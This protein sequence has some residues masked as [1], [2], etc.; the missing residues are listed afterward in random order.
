MR[1]IRFLLAAPVVLGGSFIL[2]SPAFAGD[3]AAKSKIDA[4]TVFPSGAEV[5]R[6][7]KVKLEAGEHTLLV[8]DVTAQALPTS[9]RVEA[10]TTGKLEIGSVDARKISLSSADPTVAQSARKKLSDQIEKLQDEK[11]EQ[12]NII[13]VAEAERAY[14]QNLSKLPQTSGAASSSG[15]HEDWNALFGVIG[16]HSAEVAKTVTEAKLKQRKIERDIKELRKEYETAEGRPEDRTQVRV[17]VRADAPLEATLSVRYQVGA[18]SWT[19]FYDARLATGDKE[20]GAASTLGITRRASIAQTTGEDWEDV[21]L[22]LSTTRPGTATAA[23]DL[24]MLSVDFGS[25]AAPAG[26]MSG[27]LD[28]MAQQSA[29][30]S[31]S[32]DGDLEENKR[33]LFKAKK[34]FA[35]TEKATLQQPVAASTFQTVYAIPGRTTIKTTGEAKRLQISAEGVEPTLL[36]RAVPR[37]DHTAYLYAKFNLAKSSSPMLPGQVSLFRDGVFVGS[38]AF[39]QLAPGEDYELGF[40]ADERVKVRRIVTEDKKGE[41][42]TFTTSRVEERRYANMIKNLHSRVIQLQVVDRA[43]VAMHQDIKVE[44][45]MDK[46]PQPTEKDVNDR[47]GTMV[48]EMK[49]EP[50]EEKMLGFGYRV[51]APADKAIAYKELTDEQIQSN[52]IMAK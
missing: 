3:I 10:A 36:V 30:A 15:S 49:A 5:T 42:G 28:R 37:L 24:N 43:P 47:R 20:K 41:T 11:E 8:D 18:A 17:Y 21:A 4:V 45:T 51:T 7:L 9:L 22:A 34:W 35:A 6:V 40:G 46:G 29:S 16:S 14:L 27:N 52:Q 44:F 26:S 33:I 13:H 2:S 50:D 32:A 38:G 19:A 1:I 48:W 12:Q 25:G 31:K 23:P 39:P